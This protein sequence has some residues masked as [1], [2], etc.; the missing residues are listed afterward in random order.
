MTYSMCFLWIP[1]S[2]RHRTKYSSLYENVEHGNID[3]QT[4]SISGMAR[5]QQLT[6]GDTDWER[7]WRSATLILR[8]EEPIPAC[9]G[10]SLLAQLDHGINRQ[11]AAGRNPRG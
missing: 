11:R 10:S 3:S 7:G 5:G 2:I 1:K 4:N 8:V 9:R 6:S